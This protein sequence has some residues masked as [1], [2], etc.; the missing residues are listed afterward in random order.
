M[1][2]GNK[3]S[4]RL[5]FSKPC[6]DLNLVSLSSGD[7]YVISPY[8]LEVPSK[9]G[10]GGF[11]F[12]TLHYGG[13]LSSTA[14]R[15]SSLRLAMATAFHWLVARQNP[16]GSVLEFR[17]VRELGFPRNRNS[18]AASSW[19]PLFPRIRREEPDCLLAEKTFL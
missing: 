11:L 4:L 6:R 7:I 19:G 5:L 10:R 8:A 18:S 17:G 3:T 12:C 1:S 2:S 9:A 15:A 13:A 16:V 14:S